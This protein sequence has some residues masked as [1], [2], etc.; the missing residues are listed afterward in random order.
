MRGELPNTKKPRHQ[1]RLLPQAPAAK[2]QMRR[3]RRA[4]PCSDRNDTDVFPAS[5]AF[6][7]KLHSAVDGREDRV[8][9]AKTNIHTG[10]KMCATLTHENIAPRELSRHR[11]A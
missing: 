10:V 5:R 8:V 2:Q 11:N 9:L 1:T 6:D 4:E 3:M 7:F